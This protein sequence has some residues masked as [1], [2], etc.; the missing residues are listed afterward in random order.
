VRHPDESTLALFAGGDLRLISRWPVAR[1]VSR[2]ARCG[3]AVESFRDARQALR[4]ATA[5][6]PEGLHWERLAAEMAANI[7]VGLSAGECIAKTPAPVRIAGRFGRVWK[8]ALVVGGLMLILLARW[9]LDFPAAERQEVAN[10]MQKLWPHE[11]A[12]GV[13]SSADQSVALEGSQDGLQVN[14]NG[15]SLT[16]IE[17]GSKPLLVSA[18]TQGSVRARY[19]NADTGQVTIT[20]VYTGQ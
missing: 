4:A 12:H 18:S 2:C 5:D 6:L 1:H 14:E 11:A 3:E 15:S 10:A 19:V 8:P 17:S 20:D 7:H 16:L 13:E 9:R